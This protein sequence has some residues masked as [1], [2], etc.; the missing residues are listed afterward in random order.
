MTMNT[1]LKSLLI[2]T[3][4]LVAAGISSHAQ[5]MLSRE[6]AMRY[7][8]VAAIHEPTNLQTPIRVDADLKRPVAGY[9]GD[10]GVLVLP[11]TKL[12][13]STLQG[14]QGDVIPVGQLWLKKL[15]PM[16]DGSALDESRLLMV[17]VSHEG[18]TTRVPLCLLGV[19]KTKDG[20]LELMVYGKGKEPLLKVPMTKVQR[21]QSSPIEF[22]SERESERGRVTLRFVGQYEA[23]LFLTEL[24]E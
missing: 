23:T 24:P 11:E 21:T 22:T 3:S 7:A 9:D 12:T 5:E 8:F 15:T 6:E 17:R 14:V 20:A 4:L 10:Y 18:D 13:T 2:T 1:S 19:G 16:V